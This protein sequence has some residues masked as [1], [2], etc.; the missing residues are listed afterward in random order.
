MTLLRK[1]EKSQE[2]QG[3]NP[4]TPIFSKMEEK[5]GPENQQ[6][7]RDQKGFDK[8]GTEVEEGQAG[9]SSDAHFRGP[10]EDTR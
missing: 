5:E 3:R 7:E 10:E 6:L 4:E 2:S 8:S 1:G 9:L